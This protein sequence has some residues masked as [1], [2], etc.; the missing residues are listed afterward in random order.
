MRQPSNLDELVK[1]LQARYPQA[2]AAWEQLRPS[3]RAIR[4]PACTACPSKSC[5]STKSSVVVTR[6]SDHSARLVPTLALWSARMAPPWPPL[7]IQV[8]G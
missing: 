7:T 6:Q 4:P 8:T 3:R 1:L 2:H 5:A